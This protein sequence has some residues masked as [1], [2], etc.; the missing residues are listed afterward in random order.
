MPFL[1]T[2][3]FFLLKCYLWK[4]IYF[5][6]QGEGGRRLGCLIKD[7]SP[8]IEI[9]KVPCD[10]LINIDRNL[11][12]TYGPSPQLTSARATTFKK[13]LSK[14]TQNGQKKV[15]DDPK[16]STFFQ[17]VQYCPNSSTKGPQL[18]WQQLGLKTT[19][20]SKLL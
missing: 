7:Q 10:F 4:Y 12:T 17:M 19:F 13:K 15:F 14:T 18:V 20:N 8:N 9:L 6:E 2:L 16:G 5:F 1:N 11:Q 3:C